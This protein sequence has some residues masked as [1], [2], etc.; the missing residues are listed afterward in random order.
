MSPFEKVRYLI[1]ND[2]MHPQTAVILIMR[3]ITHEEGNS[4]SA[5]EYGELW[6]SLYNEF[7]N[8]ENNPYVL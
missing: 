1:E 3:G 7:L 4:K 5:E 6:L 2:A 8:I